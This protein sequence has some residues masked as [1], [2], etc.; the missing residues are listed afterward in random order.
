MDTLLVPHP[1]S[2][3]TCVKKFCKMSFRAH[4][5][6]VKLHKNVTGIN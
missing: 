1:G 6:G 4:F 2:A 5:G 3:L